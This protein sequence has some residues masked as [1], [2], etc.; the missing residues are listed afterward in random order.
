MHSKNILH[1]DLKYE[2]ILFV[3]DS[4]QA[5][6]KL[7]D[8]GLSK[9]Y[10]DNSELTE[11]VGTIY[12]MAP[13]VLK[14]NYTTKADIWSVGVITFML[15]SSQMPF[16]G[17]KRR[18]IV[19]QI[20]EGQF[21]FKGRRW[22]RISEQAKAF[23]EELLIVDA[24]DRL[25]GPTALSS[26]WLN[27]RFAATARGPDADEENMARHAMLRYAGYTKLKKMVRLVIRSCEVFAFIFFSHL[28]FKFQALMVVAHKSSSEEIGI[29]RK[30]FQ[31]YDPKRDGVIDFDGFCS[32]LSEFG[33]SDDDLQ[34]MFEAVVSEI[35]VDDADGNA[36]MH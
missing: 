14:G 18:H 3:N 25:D 34:G 35:R 2:N 6:I 36:R 4:P 19:E 26:T 5:E 12:T 28:S 9:V 21:H 13:E 15:L 10:G 8:F 16:Y 33:H 1:R 7:I 27:R 20:L 29:L 22:R 30:V 17:R 24:D 32:A 23:I 31:K 11:G